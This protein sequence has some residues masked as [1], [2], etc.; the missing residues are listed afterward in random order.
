MFTRAMHADDF[1]AFKRSGNRRGWGFQDL[2]PGADPHG[3]NRVPGD[4]FIEAADDGFNFGELGHERLVYKWRPAGRDCSA[5]RTPIAAFRPVKVSL[6]VHS[7]PG[8]LP[9]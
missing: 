8:F 6:R 2:R 3:F 4:S 5:I 9:L 7:S 1:S